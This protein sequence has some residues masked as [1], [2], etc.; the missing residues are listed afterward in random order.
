MSATEPIEQL[1]ALPA[2]EREAFTRF[3]RE[4]ETLTVAAEREVSSLC[5]FLCYI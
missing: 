5:Y 1:K 2:G 4:L 3:F